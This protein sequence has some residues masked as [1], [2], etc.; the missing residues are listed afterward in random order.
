[1]SIPRPILCILI[2]LALCLPGCESNSTQ[3]DP[4]SDGAVVDMAGARD[5]LPSNDAAPAADANLATSA[6]AEAPEVQIC[7]LDPECGEGAFCNAEGL[8][9]PDVIEGLLAAPADGVSRAGAAP[10]ELTPDYLEPWIDKAGPDCPNNRPGRYDGALTVTRGGDPCTDTFVDGDGD[11]IFDAIWMGGAGPDRPAAGVSAGN[12]PAGRVLVL[13]RD[14][15]LRV[16]ISLDVYAV[17]AARA[18][19]FSRQLAHRLGLDPDQILVLATGARNGPDSVG[20]H[21]PSLKVVHPDESMAARLEGRGPSLGL[22]GSLPIASGTSEHWWQ[23]VAA[24]AADATARLLTNLH[25]VSVRAV[26]V[27]L[28]MQAN[29]APESPDEDSGDASDAGAQGASGPDDEQS[30]RRARHDGDPSPPVRA[31]QNRDGE[32]DPEE[33]AAWRSRPQNL[34]RNTR[35]PGNRDTSLRAIELTDTTNGEP[36][37]IVM[38]WGAR[39]PALSRPSLDAGFPGHARALLEAR[40]PGLTGIWWPGAASDTVIGGGDAFVPQTDPETGQPVDLEGQPTDFDTAAPAESSAVSLGQFLAAKALD[41][42]EAQ[43]AEP[44]E[45]S[46]ASRFVWLPMRN[47]RF[48]LAARLGLL[49]ALGDWISGRVA[50]PAWSSG[51]DTPACGGLGCARYRL[52]RL[53]IGST[54]LITTPGGLDD[55]HVQGQPKS[56]FFYAGARAFTDLDGDGIPDAEDPEIL[57]RTRGIDRETTVAAPGPL[58]PQRF[59]AIEGLVAEDR[60]IIG[61]ANGGVGSLGAPDATVNVFEGTLEPLIEQA[62]NPEYGTLVVCQLYPCNSDVQLAELADQLLAALPDALADIPGSHEARVVELALE[63]E[64]GPLDFTLETADGERLAEG[65]DLFLGPGDLV[66]IPSVDLVALDVRAGDLLA[67]PALADAPLEIAE[68]LGLELRRHPNAADVWVSTTADGGD[69]V[70]NAAC[71]LAFEG[72]CPH[73]RPAADGDPNATL[74]RTPMP[75]PR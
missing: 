61:R 74:P 47:P 22:L 9:Q 44:A 20:M 33:V 40:R 58:N 26:R 45:F 16:I 23:L 21:G 64:R 66:W 41:A 75:R 34:S 71:A 46:V 55:G 52:D 39:P 69:M 63:G 13:T 2:L 19:R 54:T 68:V 60:W 15:E 24:R 50:T 7:A 38:S 8:C 53:T 27:A 28:P 67:A 6:D 35:L 36:I 43:T 70:Y 1:M 12:A 56:E 73:P 10:F 49:P 48:V 11:G 65:P 57:I 32:Y 4:R 62:K 17:D 25:P 31:D 14:A 3:T 30:N 51:R 5:A 29:R 37:A 72:E 59:S 18:H 42:L